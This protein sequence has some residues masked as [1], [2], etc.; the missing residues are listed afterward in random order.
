MKYFNTVTTH[1]ES[2]LRPSPSIPTLSP[3]TSFN[4]A[5]IQTLIVLADEKYDAEIEKEKQ[6]TTIKNG[7]ARE[8]IGAV[9]DAAGKPIANSEGMVWKVLVYILG[10]FVLILGWSVGAI[11]LILWY[12]DDWVRLDVK[13]IYL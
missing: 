7:L 8:S 4:P 6:L 12:F 5:D 10:A 3:S 11:Y 13:I 1:A 2:I 9:G